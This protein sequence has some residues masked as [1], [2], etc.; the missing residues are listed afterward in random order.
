MMP[1]PLSKRRLLARIAI[2]F[3]VPWLVLTAFRL[4]APF[5]I[6]AGLPLWVI[7]IQT[8]P[9]LIGL[10]IVVVPLVVWF[11]ARLC[12]RGNY[13]LPAHISVDAITA[14]LATLALFVISQ[15]ASSAV[16][17]FLLLRVL[18]ISL[19]YVT[20]VCALI[21]GIASWSAWFFTVRPLR[22][23]AVGVLSRFD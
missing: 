13:A 14:P 15:L 5:L 10:S 18:A 23:Q 3:I 20:V 2:A 4:F 1:D 8:T 12:W 11:H 16:A 19:L 22:I 7:L 17:I 9:S 6:D 21:G